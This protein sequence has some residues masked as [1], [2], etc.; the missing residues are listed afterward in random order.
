L[1]S[2]LCRFGLACVVV[3]RAFG[4]SLF[5]A[6]V[7]SSR[8][9]V[10]RGARGSSQRGVCRQRFVLRTQ[11]TSFVALSDIQSSVIVLAGVGTSCCRLT[12][13]SRRTAS[14]PL[15]SS[16]RLVTSIDL[17]R[18]LVIVETQLWII[19]VLLVLLVAGNILCGIYNRRMQRSGTSSPQFKDLWERNEL[20]QLLSE[21]ERYRGKFPN[22][23]DAHMYAI[24]ALLAKK[25][26]SEARE[27]ISHL[28]QIEP[29]LNTL[30]QKWLELIDRQ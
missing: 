5:L 1:Q 2:A 22:N 3:F 27:L 29:T 15:N 18:T 19:I 13:R 28:A 30:I 12:S 9:F 8:F 23:T 14:P 25:K 6:R 4:H 17:E 20:D 21:A 16:V 7:G 24:K 10:L 26:Y 11:A